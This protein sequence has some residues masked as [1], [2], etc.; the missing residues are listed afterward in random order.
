MLVTFGYGACSLS[1][2]M[3]AFPPI[4]SCNHSPTT[5]YTRTCIYAGLLIPLHI[6]DL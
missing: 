3:L 1:L 4:P 5:I 2:Y 6:F